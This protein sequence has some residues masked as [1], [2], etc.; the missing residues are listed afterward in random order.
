MNQHITSSEVRQITEM[1]NIFDN[2][3]FAAEVERIE[4]TAAKADTIAYR[5]KKTLT[6]RVA[7]SPVTYR[8][9]SQLINE[10]IEAYKAGRLSEAE[11]LKQMRDMLKQ[12]Q[13]GSDR[14]TPARLHHYQHAPAY[15]GVLQTLLEPSLK[16]LAG[17]APDELLTDMAVRIEKI[18]E[19]RKIRDWTTN[20]DIHK[21]MMNDIEDYLYP[22]QAHYSFSVASVEMDLLH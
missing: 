4:G 20:R 11:Y 12:A 9:F 17:V 13:Q 21:G 1:V 5:L 16:S 8:R 6:E 22:L 2:E 19:Q 15:F 7:E 10:T 18:I 14:S 3:A